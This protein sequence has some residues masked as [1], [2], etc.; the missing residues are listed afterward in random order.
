MFR[1]NI[2]F[3]KNINCWGEGRAPAPRSSSQHCCNKQSGEGKGGTAHKWTPFH[4]IPSPSA[5]PNTCISVYRHGIE[6]ELRPMCHVPRRHAHTVKPPFVSL[7]TPYYFYLFL[8]LIVELLAVST[9]WV[10]PLPYPRDVAAEQWSICMKS[11]M[12]YAAD[13]VNTVNNFP[14]SH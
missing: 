8:Q 13:H 14:P 4:W 6:G 3:V 2:C 9:P 7:R 1:P 10:P 5:C 11:S 12:K